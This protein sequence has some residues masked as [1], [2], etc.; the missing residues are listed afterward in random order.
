MVAHADVAEEGAWPWI[1][2]DPDQAKARRDIAWWPDPDV[3]Y[4]LLRHGAIGPD[5]PFEEEDAVVRLV[6]RPDPS[7][8]Q[9]DNDSEPIVLRCRA[10]GC[11]P[12]PMPGM[13][14]TA[15]LQRG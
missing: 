7:A 15:L 4:T 12:R 3:T 14:A 2:T 8:E 5:D 11:Q 9:D 1:A 10:D 6:A 13:A